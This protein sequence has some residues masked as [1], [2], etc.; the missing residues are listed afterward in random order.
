MGRKFEVEE[1]DRQHYDKWTVWWYEKEFWEEGR[2]ENAEFA[3]NEWPAVGQ[4]TMIDY[5]HIYIYVY[6]YINSGF[7]AGF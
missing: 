2:V 6:V 7:L 5:I 1:D 3:V 4:N